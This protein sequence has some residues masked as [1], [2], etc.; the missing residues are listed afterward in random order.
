MAAPLNPHG[1]SSTSAGSVRIMPLGDSITDG[2]NAYPGGYRVAL[3]QRLAADGHAVDFVGSLANGPVELG[4]RHHEGHSG[5]RID[6]L[7]AHIRAWL[8]HSVPHTVL[9]LIGTNDM[10]Q[11]HDAVQAPTCLA[12]LI[13][14]IQEARPACELF[15]A[16][17]PPQ[18]D[19]T[20]ERRVKTYNAALPEVVAAKGQRVH[21]VN[22]YDALTTA[23]LA[24]GIHPNQAGHEKMARVW[25][26]AL[27]SVPA[28][29]TPAV[30]SL[31]TC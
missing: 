24:D 12:R 13:D 15:V 10:N 4:T 6:H 22:M 23:D 27:R 26:G 2:H 21:L 11:N 28:A 7:D 14:H 31:A 8:R 18:S 25:H 17:V 5:W 20:R 16:T 1:H 19:P 29:L 3:W 9:L 30:S